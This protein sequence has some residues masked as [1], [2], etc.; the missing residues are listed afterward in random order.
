[1]V[2]LMVL[3][4]VLYTSVFLKIV[5][6]FKNV[7]IP[8]KNIFRIALICDSVFLIQNIIKAFFL[9]TQHVSSF[10]EMSYFSPLSVLSFFK[11]DSV[12]LYLV[13]PLQLLNLFEVIYVITLTIFFLSFFESN[14][15]KSL[16]YN[17]L[18]YGMAFVFWFILA[19]FINMAF[20]A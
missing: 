10:I 17:L 18:G 11:K 6:F 20:T 2:G 8:F 1:M 12:E 14:F 16:N 19:L 3:I 15:K 4:R 13:Y 7:K 5:F 9:K